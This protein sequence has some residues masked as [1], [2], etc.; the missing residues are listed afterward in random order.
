MATIC[1]SGG[2]DSTV[3]M[4]ELAEQGRLNFAV[5]CNFG[6]PSFKR[7][8][9]C[10]QYHVD[11]LNRQG[12]SVELKVMEFIP[13]KEL[14]YLGESTPF[15]SSRPK[16]PLE[17]RP[18]KGNDVVKYRWDNF[19]ITPGRNALM[20]LFA[21]MVSSRLEP[22]VAEVDTAYQF[23]QNIW[24]LQDTIAGDEAPTFWLKMEMVLQSA[25]EVPVQ[26]E[27]PFLDRHWDKKRIVQEGRS[28]G[29]DFGKTMSCE[30]EVPCGVC[31]QCRLV[32]K[33][34]IGG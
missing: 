33:T 9:K 19:A 25:F 2:I 20:I 31:A 13:P 22:D 6:Q 3:L 8:L 7:Q 14:L 27:Q 23:E 29:V 24:D 12:C 17:R 4:Y 30:F 21:G 5:L 18:T 1:Y 16:N 32:T 34:L 26:L 11:F 28:L 10:A 15:F